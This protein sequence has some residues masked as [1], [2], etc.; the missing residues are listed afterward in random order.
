MQLVP[1]ALQARRGLV[2]QLVRPVQRDQPERQGLPVPPALRVRRGLRDLQDR[3]VRQV[4]LGLLV[5]RGLLALRARLDLPVRQ[6]QR[7][8]RGLPD[9]LALLVQQVL[10]GLMEPALR[11]GIRAT[12]PSLLPVPPGRWIVR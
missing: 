8:P 12:S 9:P 4:L 5:L 10:P 11:M 1:L 6:V 3:R 2:E 7:E